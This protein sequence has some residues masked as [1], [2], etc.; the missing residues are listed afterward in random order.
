MDYDSAFSA[1][2]LHFRS[3]MAYTSPVANISLSSF[4]SM[5]ACLSIL[6]SRVTPFTVLKTLDANSVD[7]CVTSPPYWGL[8]DYKTDGQLGLE[9][10]FHQ[11]LEH[12]IEI[13][14]EVKRVIKKTGS[15][16]VNIGDSYNDNKSLS[17]I[18]ERFAIRMTDELGLIRRNTIIWHKPNCM[19]SSARDRFTVDFEYIY[20]FSKS[21]RYHFETQYEPLIEPNRKRGTAGDVYGGSR[22]HEGYGESCLQW[23]CYKVL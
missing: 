21:P 20:F 9:P 11:Y 15:I 4:V 14:A 6:S 2:L 22:K 10:T 7:M 3:V 5:W 17:G 16:W 13:F 23:E 8:R 18:P 1:H 12:L 19:P